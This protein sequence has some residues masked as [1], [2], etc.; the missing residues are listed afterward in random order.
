ME[1]VSLTKGGANLLSDVCKGG[2][3]GKAGG[4]VV[5]RGVAPW[6]REE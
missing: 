3:K 4:R 2:G 5:Q 1:V 6:R